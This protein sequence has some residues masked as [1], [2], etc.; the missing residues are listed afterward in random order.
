MIC[1]YCEEPI[2]SAAEWFG[3]EPLHVKCYRLLGEELESRDE[4]VRE[5]GGNVP[6]NGGLGKSKDGTTT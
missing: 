2:R 6:T 4:G 3:G 1:I 5:N